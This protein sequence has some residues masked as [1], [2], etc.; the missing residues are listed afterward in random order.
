MPALGVGGARPG[1]VEFEGVHMG[2]FWMNP[3]NTEAYEGHTLWNARLEL[4]VTRSAA[5]FM[6]VM[7]VSDRTYA[8]RASFNAFRGAELN[9]GKPRTVFLGLRWEGGAR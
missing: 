7:N 3:E 2:E 1:F 6:R 8:E 5:V 4:P 9:P